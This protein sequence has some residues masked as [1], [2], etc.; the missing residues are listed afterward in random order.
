MTKLT[1][2]PIKPTPNEQLVEDLE[3]LLR[4]ARSGQLTHFVVVGYLQDDSILTRYSPGDTI[5]KVGLLENA[6][7]VLLTDLEVCDVPAVLEP[8]DA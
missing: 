6:K 4:Y 5:F 7:N 1:S 2:I 8:S 3:F